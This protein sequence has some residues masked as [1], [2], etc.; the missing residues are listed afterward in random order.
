MVVLVVGDSKGIEWEVDMVKQ[1]VPPEA[2]LLYIPPKPIGSKSSR[3]PKKNK[4][5]YEAFRKMI[6]ERLPAKLPEF[7]ES[8]FC[9]GFTRQWVPI[10]GRCERKIWALASLD[11]TSKQVREQLKYVLGK[12][13]PGVELE[14]YKVFG[15]GGQIMRIMASIVIFAVGVYLG[16]LALP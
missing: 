13:M 16:I 12:T 15:R 7:E 9:I 4:D 3:R 2:L 5:I 8:V 11:R 10:L 1:L 6:E 14:S